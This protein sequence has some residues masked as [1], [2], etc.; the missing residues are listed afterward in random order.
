MSSTAVQ[1]PFIVPVLDNLTIGRIIKRTVNGS[2]G[3]T[4][5]GGGWSL[6]AGNYTAR[7]VVEGCAPLLETVLHHLGPD[8]PNGPAARHMLLDN[9]SSN[10]DLGTR[11][12]SLHI[13]TT[14][15]GRKEIAH[16][17]VTIG[18][19]LVHYAAETRDAHFDPAF[20]I[21]SPCDGHLLKHP[22]AELMFGPRSQGHLM[23]IYNEYLH[24]M[25][26]L[27]DALLCFENFEEV[28]IPIP[29]NKGRNLGMRYTEQNRSLFLAELMTKSLTQNGVFK[30]AIA[31]LAPELASIEGYG[32][33]YSQGL[34][35]PSFVAGSDARRLL[36]YL[37][38][39]LDD[40]STSLVFRNEHQDYYTAPRSEIAMATNTLKP[41]SSNAA[42][43]ST[44]TRAVP[45]TW[46]AVDSESTTDDEPSRVLK[47]HL[48]FSENKEAIVDLGQI[49]RG[50]RY[51][52]SVVGVDKASYDSGFTVPAHVHSAA[53]VLVRADFGLVTAKD[54]GIHLIPANSNVILLALLGTLSPENVI[55]VG[56]GGSLADAERA[57]KAL[58]NSPKFVLQICNVTRTCMPTK[59]Y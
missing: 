24:Q 23:Q 43:L 32:C 39:K 19:K 51:A 21:R 9:L 22:V 40:T 28:V 44:P 58:P 52:Y 42:V 25:V 54:G 49:S 14:D 15:A 55:V 3:A 47:L 13:P 41:G 48:R 57:G 4:M 18:K 46:I 30:A 7:Q 56:P 31:L 1:Q 17:A 20:A 6:R 36:R 10:L 53:D 34:I 2:N 45:A 8:P 27:R 38:V 5:T 50:R 12:S 11:E 26:L 59:G 35:L 16:Q 37:P 29:G 33:Q